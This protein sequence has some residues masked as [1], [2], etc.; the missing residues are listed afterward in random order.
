MADHRTQPLAEFGAP[1]C[2][3][4]LVSLRDID[5][6][7]PVGMAHCDRHRSAARRFGQQVEHRPRTV[8]AGNEPAPPGQI[9]KNPAFRLFGLRPQ[10]P[11]FVVKP[12]RNN[13]GCH[14]GAAQIAGRVG[15]PVA[16]D[17]FAIG[18]ASAQWREAV[19]IDVVNDFKTAYAS[20]ALERESR[21]A[22]RTCMD[23]HFYLGSVTRR[24]A[25]L[26][27]SAILVP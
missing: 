20:K 4:G 3:L 16:P 12:V 26:P 6:H 7:H 19:A 10:G 18:A 23:F 11:V 24:P 15:G 13:L 22:V 25:N 2:S 1:L 17:R 9:G 27:A 21:P 14:A 8:I 5:R